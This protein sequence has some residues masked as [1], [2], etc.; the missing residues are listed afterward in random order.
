MSMK[1][2]FSFI[3]FFS[4]LSINH[5]FSQTY[6]DG[7]ME[8]QIRVNEIR[9]DYGPTNNTSNDFT[10]NFSQFGVS[11]PSLADDELTF[12]VWARA[13]P[14]LT[15]LGW[16][17]GNCL[18]ADMPMST[19]GPE[20]AP[21]FDLLFSTIY[22][23]PNV[24]QFYDLRLDA[25]EDDLNSDFNIPQI[26]SLTPCS[27]GNN[28]SRCDFN[29]STCC[30]NVPIFGCL[31]TESDDIRCN[32][33]PFL[34][35]I[36]YRAVGPPCRW[37]SHGYLTGNC[38]QNNFYFPRIETFYR[39]TKGTACTVNDAI[40]LGLM[41]SGNT[42]THFNSNECYSNNFASSPGN[43][44]FYKFTINN[45]IGLNISVCGVSTTFD[46][47]MYL[48]DNNCNIIE[49]DDDG[50]GNQS[51][52]NK[53]LCRTGDYYVVIDGKNANSQGT[54]T[55][56]I[57]ENTNFT[58]AVSIA[59]TNPSCFGF[60]DGEAEVNITGGISPF[61]ILWSN[62][63]S[64]TITT[65]LGAGAISVTVTDFEGCA[66]TAN[67]TL[68]NPPQMAISTSSVPV[69]CGGAND[70]SATATPSGGTPPYT[71]LWNSTPVQN[72]NPAILLPDGS[73]S[74]L[75][76]DFNGCT[77][78]GNVTVGA[79]TAVIIDIIS[80]NDI[81][82]F[83]ENDGAI[84]ISAS[85]GAPPYSPAWTNS[86]VTGF[87]ASN[88]PPGPISVTVF[89]NTGTCNTTRA[90]NIIEPP[91]LTSTINAVRDV[92]CNGGSD[93]AIDLGVAGG[94]IPYNYNWTGGTTGE[95]LLNATAGN[96]SV[97]VT[98][99]NGCTVENSQTLSEPTAIS[100]LISS[101]DGGCEGDSIGSAD[102]SVSGG[103]PPYVYFWSN[104][105]TT[106]DIN[107]VPGGTYIAV[108]TDASNCVEVA[109]VTI[110]ELPA[111]TVQTSVTR[112]SCVGEEDGIIRLN[113][114]GAPPYSYVWFDG[115]TNSEIENIPAG[116]YNVTVTDNNDCE[117]I[118]TILV[119]EPSSI[120]E[121][122]PRNDF[123]AIPNAFTPNGDGENDYFDVWAKGVTR[124]SV[125]IYNRWGAKIYENPNQQPNIQGQGWD[126]RA[127]GKEAM[128]GSY[129]YVM[130][131]EYENPE[132]DLPGQR[133]GSVTLLR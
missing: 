35:S 31:L 42:I 94:T 108:I 132:I 72:G 85:G 125:K 15:T 124:I 47:Y 28:F 37:N 40:D 26:A 64:D 44:V 33:D 73:Y 126:G 51:V 25:W 10:L 114:S 11:L 23:T 39:Y 104:F 117:N 112:P 19:G 127:F 7:P 22:N 97:T 79:A 6:N 109:S 80:Y 91:L 75:V 68:T 49:F 45:P 106:Q 129:V 18:T 62:G 78:S 12:K 93:G 24:P 70:G 5:I 66:A 71:Y 3:L 53:S 59:S 2:Y 27:N 76:T 61:T 89:D 118:V 58:Y 130:E 69:S 92:N 98:D 50:C 123:V 103:V 30:L 21:V 100:A 46:T 9:V 52:I 55:L 29:T 60:N 56:T 122:G 65:G 63:Q 20:I 4:L 105:A 82:C 83:G 128:P 77:A 90:F 34:T 87:S 43:D 96:Y 14:D 102:L 107:N 86:S 88:L 67:A 16:Q 57:S 8:L 17:G 38:P 110:E 119:D 48:L 133:T 101:T 74:V 95:D 41:Q 111:L 131:I 84:T 54:F 113:A 13:N 1:H 32:A 81:T 99:A 121:C 116:S 115:S 36:D 120:S